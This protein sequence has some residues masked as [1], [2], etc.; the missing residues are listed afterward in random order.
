MGIRHRYVAALIAVL[1]LSGCSAAAGQG[2]SPSAPTPKPTVSA[3]PQPV[4]TDP[5]ASASPAASASEPA[6]APSATGT[7]TAK[8][9]PVTVDP[10][11]LP[12]VLRSEGAPKPTTTAEPADTKAKVEY[13]D[14]VTLRITDVEFG[15]ETKEGPGRFPGREY[16]ILSLEINNLGKTAINLDTTVVTVLDKDGQQV[17]PVYV[18]EA[19]VSDFSGPV[20]PGATAKARYAFAVPKESRSQVTVVVDFDSVHTSAVFSGELN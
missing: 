16:A 4:S 20:A 9:S 10:T 1:A 2:P 6:P 13:S 18:E 3:P 8:P 5:G 12:K 7:P 19:E 14:G 11:P 17:A 15:E